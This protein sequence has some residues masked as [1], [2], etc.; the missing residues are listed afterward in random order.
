MQ[1]SEL[2]HLQTGAHLLCSEAKFGI[3]GRHRFLK[4]IVIFYV[5][6]IDLIFEIPLGLSATSLILTKTPNTTLF[7]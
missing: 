3:D 6:L 4:G 5:D 7:L 1:I 2:C